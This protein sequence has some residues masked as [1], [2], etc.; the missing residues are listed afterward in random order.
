MRHH[1]LRDRLKEA[2]RMNANGED[3]DDRRMLLRIVALLFALADL[4]ECAI[5]RSE[6]VRRLVLLILRPAEAHVRRCFAPDAGTPGGPALA[7]PMPSADSASEAMR[8][9]VC[10]R[11]LAAT[12]HRLVGMPAREC[13]PLPAD[14]QG[15]G[16]LAATPVRRRHTI[17]RR[18]ARLHQFARDGPQCAGTARG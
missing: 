6:A 14:C 11:A 4:A 7:A 15:I 12:L 17:L 8:L 13:A 2:E 3:D 1:V 16:I 18:L 5:G 10:F 9:A